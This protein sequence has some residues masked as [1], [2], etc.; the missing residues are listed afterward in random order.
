MNRV[1]CCVFFYEIRVC[2]HWVL[3]FDNFFVGLDDISLFK[4]IKIRVL[5][6][7]LFLLLVQ[8]SFYAVHEAFMVELCSIYGGFTFDILI[9]RSVC[10]LL[11]FLNLD[12]FCSFLCMIM[13]KFAP[14]PAPNF[15]FLIEFALD[16]ILMK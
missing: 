11:N 13:C 6:A 8:V 2:G 16:L 1:L 3:G 5:F 14:K 4:V 12:C 9:D 7:I 10:D 15:E